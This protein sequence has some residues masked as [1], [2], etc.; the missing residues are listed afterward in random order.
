MRISFK[1][2]MLQ[3]LQHWR[4]CFPEIKNGLDFGR[5]LVV[6]TVKYDGML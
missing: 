5:Y 6:I 1:V 2:Q 3:R 4:L